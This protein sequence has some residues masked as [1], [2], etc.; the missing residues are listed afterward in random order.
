LP[1]GRPKLIGRGRRHRLVRAQTPSLGRLP[2]LAV[3]TA[4]LILNGCVGGGASAGQSA[5][6]NSSV[7][8]GPS[9][10]PG[11]SLDP[12][13]LR[14]E[15]VDRFGPRWYCDPD[16]YPIARPS[17]DE[18]ATAVERFPEMQAEGV[19]F[20]A[21]VRRLGLAGTTTFSAAQELAIYRQWKVLASLALDPLGNGSYRFDYVAQPVGGSSSGVETKG[22]ID[23]SG[24][25]RIDA[26]ASAAAPNCPI[27]LARGTPI[28]APG[29]EIA[30]ER[31]A[32]GD[33]VW[34]LDRAGLGVVGTVIAIGSTVAPLNHRVIHLVL[35]D[36]RF[37]SASPGHPLAD[38]R[39]LGTL[40]IG[41][42]VD[43]S[44]VLATTSLPYRGGE[45]FDLV[46]SGETG[47]YLSDGIPLGTTLR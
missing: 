3:L 44:P 13:D 33:Q 46:V 24:T 28:D 1:A 8:P 39:R 15:L 34:T 7:L 21:I 29:G 37:V 19:I 45:T 35:A 22:T 17:Y 47:N 38:G 10:A 11:A 30:V 42:L 40:R 26:T 12:G 4:A 25:I 6:P 14:L 20:E 5:N 32:L 31:L 27:C 2:F 43:G 18:G 16:L 23:S 41:D 36:G 9:I